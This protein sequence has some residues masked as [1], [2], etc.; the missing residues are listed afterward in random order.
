MNSPAEVIEQ[1]IE[2]INSSENLNMEFTIAAHDDPGLSETIKV[3]TSGIHKAKTNHEDLVVECD[4]PGDDST[5]SEFAAMLNQ[6][7]A[8][9][10]SNYT[11]QLA[12]KLKFTT[13]DGKAINS[14]VDTF[15]PFP[16]FCSFRVTCED[17][18][19]S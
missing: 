6:M 1:A 14:T 7:T 3:A 5:N 10:N 17:I 9:Y 12:T 4:F 13:G 16:K 18:E 19:I 15:T 11:H 8:F 2:I